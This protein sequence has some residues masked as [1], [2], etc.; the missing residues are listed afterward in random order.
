MKK[1]ILLRFW[2]LS[3][4]VLLSAGAMAQ[5]LSLGAALK[6]STLGFG[7]DA[8]LGINDKMAVRLGYDRMSLGFNFDFE[9]QDVQYDVNATVKTGSLLALY[10]YYLTKYIYVTGGAGV[11]FF[12][13]SAQGNAASSL[14]WGDIEIPKEKVGNFTF[15]FDP[16]FKISPYF[17][18]GFGRSLGIDK[19]LAMGFDL[20]AFYQGSPDLSIE[21]SGMLTPTG[22]PAHGHEEKIEGQVSAYKVYPVLKLSISYKILDL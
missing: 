6:G 5:N 16:G 22:D 14:P 11:N 9:E 12:N 20:G 2:L 10:D 19:K 4:C 15:D 21:T 17:G 18:L 13:I 8:I 3:I 7:A 1:R